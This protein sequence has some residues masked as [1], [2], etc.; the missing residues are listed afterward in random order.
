MAINTTFS[1]GAVLTATQMNNLPFGV[2]GVQTITS[3]FT[4]SAVHTTP[5]A[6]GM[7][8]TITEV[9]GRRYR[10]TAYSNLYPPGGLQGVNIGINRAGTQLKQGVYASNIMNTGTAYPTVFTY[11]YTAATSGS[12]TYTVSVWAATSNTAVA[13]YGD[14]T[15]PRQFCIEDIGLS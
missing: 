1:S 6:N 4:T 14:T 2:C 9:A 10:I 5:Q 12:A 7:T 8:L 3:T 11:I 15:F 13:D